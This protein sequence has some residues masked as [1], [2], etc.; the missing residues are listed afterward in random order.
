MIGAM[1]AVAV[2][3]ERRRQ[4]K[5]LK[6]PSQLYLSG[7]WLPPLQGSPP[8]PSP[9]GHNNLEPRP[10]LYLCGKISGLHAVVVCL[11]LGAVVLVVGLVQLAPGATTTNHRLALLVAGTALLIMGFVLAAVRCYVIHC[12]PFPVESP[13]ATPIPQP[14]SE[15]QAAVHKGTLDLLVGHQS[16]PE[17]DALMQHHHHNNHRIKRSSQGS[18]SEE[19]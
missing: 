8:T 18:H 13:V 5:R 15:P 1:P 12:L 19:A 14:T 7:Q 2:R 4:E 16:Q 3:H 11:L 6:R 10:E 17:T 9:H